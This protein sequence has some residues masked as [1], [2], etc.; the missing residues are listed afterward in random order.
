MSNTIMKQQNKST[1]GSFAE[2]AKP[3]ETSKNS[4]FDTTKQSTSKYWVIKNWVVF[5][6]D[7]DNLR[8]VSNLFEFDSWVKIDEALELFFHSKVI[9]NL[10][11]VDN[12]LIEL[13]RDSLKFI[14]NPGKW[15]NFGAF[16]LSLKSG[17]IS[18]MNVILER[19]WRAD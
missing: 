17:T 2:I 18:W 16:H 6:A 4:F 8:V 5:K 1:K 12:S 7:F 15:Q 10:L 14:E 19:L 9:I 11:F 3:K 13:E